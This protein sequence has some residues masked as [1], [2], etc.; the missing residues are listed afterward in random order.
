MPG[1]GE[2][3]LF[4]NFQSTISSTVQYTLFRGTITAQI[5]EF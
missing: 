2:L 5:C 4:Q 1:A 3:V